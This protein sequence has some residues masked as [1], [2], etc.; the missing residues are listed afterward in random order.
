MDNITAVSPDLMV[1][2]EEEIFYIIAI[3]IVM[4]MI[5]WLLIRG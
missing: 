5:I 1:F 2:L 3:V 4:V